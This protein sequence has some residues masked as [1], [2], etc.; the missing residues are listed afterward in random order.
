MLGTE[1]YMVRKARS[2]LLFPIVVSRFGRETGI[3]AQFTQVRCCRKVGSAWKMLM[4]DEGAKKD[5]A[6][7]V[8]FESGSE[9]CRIWG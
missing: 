8:I 6:E 9:N 4:R 3:N 1:L 7:E 5:F 2:D